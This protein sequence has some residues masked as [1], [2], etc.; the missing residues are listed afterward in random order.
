MSGSK[1]AMGISKNA[2]KGLILN[3]G[4]A[5]KLMGKATD[6]SANLVLKLSK[7]IIKRTIKKALGSQIGY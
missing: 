2:E 5:V 7:Q 6:L 4:T 1:L 3:Q